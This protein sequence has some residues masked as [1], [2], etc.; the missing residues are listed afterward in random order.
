MGTY[1][2]FASEAVERVKKLKRQGKLEKILQSVPPDVPAA[3]IPTQK[4]D[5]KEESQHNKKC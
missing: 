1:G 4:V 3:K 2:A 5:Q